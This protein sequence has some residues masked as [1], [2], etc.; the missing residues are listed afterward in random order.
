MSRPAAH[1]LL[2]SH[3]QAVDLAR[4]SNFCLNSPTGTGTAVTPGVSAAEGVGP[5]G[6]VLPSPSPSASRADDAER[7]VLPH[8]YC[9]SPGA[10]GAAA[11][12]LPGVGGRSWWQLGLGNPGGSAAQREA[13][14]ASGSRDRGPAVMEHL[15]LEVAAAPLHLIA[16]KNE[17][18][19]NELGRFL[20]KQ[21]R[22]R[23]RGKTPRRPRPPCSRVPR[24]PAR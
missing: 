3:H 4:K 8:V 6:T 11:A 12:A 18:S 21:V 13:G 16:A 24:G 15:S 22:T 9:P 17:K 19:R 5:G 7:R 14:S 23:E 2:S 10:C 1:C 20:A